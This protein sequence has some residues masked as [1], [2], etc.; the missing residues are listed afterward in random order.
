VN[1]SERLLTALAG[2]RPDRVPVTAWFSLRWLSDEL[3]QPPRRFLDT[4]GRD[5]LHSIIAMQEAWGF[6]P[7][8]LSFTELEDEVID[9][10]GRYF[11][12]SPAAWERWQVERRVVGWEDRVPTIQ[13]I[14]TT[15]A[16][17]LTSQYRAEPCQKWTLEY[18]LKKEADLDLL[19]DRPDPALLNVDRLVTLVKAVGERGVVLHV[20]PGV[21]YDACSLR[22]VTQLCL[23]LYDRPAWV[24]RFMETECAYLSGL[25]QRVCTAGLKVVQIDESWIGVGLSRQTYE[26]FVLPYDRALVG[27]AKEAGLLVD[28]HN[29]GKVTAILESMVATGSDALEPLTPPSLN[30]DIRLADAKR[31]VGDRIC[32]YGGLNERV[33]MSDD[34]EE[35]R[36]E[37]RRCIDE[38]GAGGGYAIRCAGQIFEGRL[39]NLRIMTGEAQSY[40][41]Y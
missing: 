29:C 18:L 33:L 35:V 39:E 2:G 16:G 34:P 27:V 14:I 12:W 26:E 9:W 24:K 10:P 19:S 40:G 4:F 22:G 30:G 38:A 28:Y 15:P 31:R 37:V 3:G 25:L 1:S 36:A 5:P 32:L 20:F 11:S 23:D 21:W 7:L 6:D 8:F 17:R 13:R 41:K